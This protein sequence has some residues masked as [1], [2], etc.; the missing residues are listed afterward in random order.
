[1][2]RKRQIDM[3]DQQKENEKERFEGFVV[4]DQK[5]LVYLSAYVYVS[6]FVRG[7]KEEE[8]K[9]NSC[10]VRRLFRKSTSVLSGSLLT[11]RSAKP[12]KNKDFHSISPT[13]LMREKRQ[14]RGG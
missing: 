11:S 8:E 9:K 7:V 1:M 2:I 13:I 12:V 4:Y 6:L 3:A 5:A 14:R 10:Y